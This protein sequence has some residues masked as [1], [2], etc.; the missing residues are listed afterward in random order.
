MERHEER[1]SKPRDTLSQLEEAPETAFDCLTF[2]EV[3]G[4]LKK[5]MAAA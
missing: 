4:V 5:V 2:T 3:K 1:H